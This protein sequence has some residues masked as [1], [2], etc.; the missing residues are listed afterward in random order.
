[1]P[2]S[3]YSKSLLQHMEVTLFFHVSLLRL[4]PAEDSFHLLLCVCASTTRALKL[5]PSSTV[6]DVAS[7]FTPAAFPPARA[8]APQELP[9]TFMKA[10]QGKRAA[11]NYLGTALPANYHITLPH[12]CEE[13]CH[14]KRVTSQGQGQWR[15]FTDLNLSASD[16]LQRWT[17]K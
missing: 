14:H 1:M 5:Q 2:G 9:M 15:S 7:C 12:A 10:E 3:F 11:Q 13:M 4:P 16:H 6:P 17:S 8:C